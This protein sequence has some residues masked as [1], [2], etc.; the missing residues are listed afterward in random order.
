M[1]NFKSWG[2]NQFSMEVD[3]Y[4]LIDVTHGSIFLLSILILA[5][6]FQLGLTVLIKLELGNN[7]IGSLKSDGHL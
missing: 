3:Y 1:A 4:Y 6:G 2:S 7:K 5:L